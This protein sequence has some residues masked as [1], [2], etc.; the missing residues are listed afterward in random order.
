M[1]TYVLTYHW[2]IPVNMLDAL[3]KAGID[4]WMQ[5]W[6][7][8]IFFKGDKGLLY[9]ADRINEQT[10]TGPFFVSEYD[11]RRFFGWMPPTVW[12]WAKPAAHALANS[13]DELARALPEPL[14]HK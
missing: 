10:K 2:A 9:Y 5:A 1:K 11:P 3:E 12:E 14:Q 7:G 8:L 6:P 13:P 4:E